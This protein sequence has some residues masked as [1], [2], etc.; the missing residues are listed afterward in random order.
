MTRLLQALLALVLVAAVGLAVYPTLSAPRDEDR[1]AAAEALLWK[2]RGACEAFHK[3]HGRFAKEYCAHPADVCELS[4]PKAASRPYLPAPLQPWDA[5][6]GVRIH[7][8]S[9]S[10]RPPNK[11]GFD[12]DGDGKFDAPRACNVARFDYA[13]YHLAEALDRKL[14]AGVP[15]DWRRTGRGRFFGELKDKPGTYEVLLFP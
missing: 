9:E 11:D 13:E 14:D 6:I 7:V 8:L 2:L 3:D 5:H 15:G 12:T 4:T 10:D 1:V